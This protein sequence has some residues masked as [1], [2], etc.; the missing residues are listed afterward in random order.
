MLC[1][2][3]GNNIV[4]KFCNKR[5]CIQGIPPTLYNN[6]YIFGDF[7]YLILAFWLFN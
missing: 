1:N 4:D 7:F 5:F 6:N 2:L 3:H